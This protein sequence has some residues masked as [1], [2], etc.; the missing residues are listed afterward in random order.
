M[1]TEKYIPINQYLSIFSLLKKVGK[2]ILKLTGRQIDD[3]V[4]IE[5]TEEIRTISIMTII[6]IVTMLKFAIQQRI[7]ICS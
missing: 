1:S 6:T 3:F 7:N 2:K 5:V 4:C